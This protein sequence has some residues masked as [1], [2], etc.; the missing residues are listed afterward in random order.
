MPPG[1]AAANKASKSANNSS[2]FSPGKYFSLKYGFLQSSPATLKSPPSEI[3]PKS[4]SNRPSAVSA[5]VST[6][7]GATA[8]P[9][10]SSFALKTGAALFCSQAK[11]KTLCASLPYFLAN[12]ATIPASSA[13]DWH[14]VIEPSS[15]PSARCGSKPTGAPNSSK[16][17]E[18][19]SGAYTAV[20]KRNAERANLLKIPD[21]SGKPTAIY[22]R[23]LSFNFPNAIS[24][25]SA[26]VGNPCALKAAK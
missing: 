25:A 24:R 13:T 26:L 19:P 5:R 9:F 6:F 23:P 18:S 2:A 7:R 3:C 12:S 8:K 17:S 14:T 11:A 20:S 21:T 1:I 10:A 16:N 22:L 15:I 4:R